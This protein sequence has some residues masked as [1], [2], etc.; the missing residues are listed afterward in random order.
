LL[1]VN[2]KDIENTTAPR[3][4]FL[5]VKMDTERSKVNSIMS[6]EDYSTYVSMKNTNLTSKNISKYK[7]IKLISKNT[8]DEMMIKMR[9][10][11][12]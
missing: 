6:Y 11:A 10:E 5:R 4:S 8:Y 12:A 2:D 9:I 3:I 1:G 7:H